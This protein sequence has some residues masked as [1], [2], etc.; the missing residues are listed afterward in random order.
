MTNDERA[1]EIIG[2]ILTGFPEFRQSIVENALDAAEDRGRQ[3]VQPTEYMALTT[4]LV[5]RMESLDAKINKPPSE[6]EDLKHLSGEARRQRLKSRAYIW[7][8]ILNLIEQQAEASLLA[9]FNND[10]DDLQLLAS[11][12]IAKEQAITAEFERLAGEESHVPVNQEGSREEAGMPQRSVIDE[13]KQEALSCQGYKIVPLDGWRAYTPE[14]EYLGMEE[15][16]P[17]AWGLC[18]DHCEGVKMP[19]ETTSEERAES[20]IRGFMSRSWNENIASVAA[21]IREAE[22]R[23]YERAQ[24]GR[25]LHDDPRNVG[26]P[27]VKS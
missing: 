10:Y 5:N 4:D 3:S 27:E 7:G 13:D 18:A 8:H 16:I 21:A 15:S 9:H 11:M 19:E 6:W 26:Q 2:A 22:Q 20:A 1:Y 25:L 12:M 17:Q 23:G 14:G 24:R